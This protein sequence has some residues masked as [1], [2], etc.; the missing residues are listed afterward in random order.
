[1]HAPSPRLEQDWSKGEWQWGKGGDE[2][3]GMQGWGCQAEGNR[4]E[5]G[6]VVGVEKQHESNCRGKR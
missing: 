3:R 1:M 6:Q 5:V 2:G 4:Q